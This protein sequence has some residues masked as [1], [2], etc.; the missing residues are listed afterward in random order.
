MGLCSE[1]WYGVAQPSYRV[2]WRENR[3]DSQ[4]AELG[5]RVPSPHNLHC[6]PSTDSRWLINNEASPTR[7]LAPRLALESKGGAPVA[8]SNWPPQATKLDTSEVPRSRRTPRGNAQRETELCLGAPEGWRRSSVESRTGASG[9]SAVVA[10]GWGLEM[11]V[12]FGVRV[13]DGMR[14]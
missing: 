2:A 6:L 10:R 13:R 5:S 4:E 3:I 14:G 12:G 11:A 9:T 1:V 8:L 7:R